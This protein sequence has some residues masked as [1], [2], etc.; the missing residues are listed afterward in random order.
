MVSTVLSIVPLSATVAEITTVHE[1]WGRIQ[2]IVVIL[3]SDSCLH[4]EISPEQ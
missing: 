3:F 4:T 1:R 2:T